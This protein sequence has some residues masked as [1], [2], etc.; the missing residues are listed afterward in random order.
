MGI[1]VRKQSIKINK[2]IQFLCSDHLVERVRL[3]QFVLSRPHQVLG[4]LVNK[5]AS[6]SIV[7]SFLNLDGYVVKDVKS[8]HAYANRLHPK[9]CQRII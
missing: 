4:C 6:S 9:V 7:K 2:L 3:S 5:V 1:K 8:P